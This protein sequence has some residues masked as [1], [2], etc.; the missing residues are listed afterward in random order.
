M[1]KK[2]CPPKEIV[3]VFQETVI[4]HP[5][6]TT[7]IAVFEVAQTTGIPH[8]EGFHL[9]CLTL[10]TWDCFIVCKSRG[11]MSPLKALSVNANARKRVIGQ[12]PNPKS[13]RF[14]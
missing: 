1:G 7:Q 10:P 6:G 5:L 4:G 3:I 2:P 9:R 14:S 13:F 8:M 11:L 12:R